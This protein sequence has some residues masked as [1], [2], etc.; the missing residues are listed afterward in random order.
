MA[1]EDQGPVLLQGQWPPE[2]ILFVVSLFEH[3]LP[4]DGGL[5]PGGRVS[6][7]SSCEGVVRLASGGPVVRRC[8]PVEDGLE[9]VPIGGQVRAG[10]IGTDG[11]YFSRRGQRGQLHLEEISLGA[12]ARVPQRT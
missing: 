7:A 10:E 2:E 9:G 4:D 3:D 8:V 12:E 5:G 6:G 1:A 11:G